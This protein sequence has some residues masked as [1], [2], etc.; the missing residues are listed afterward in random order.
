MVAICLLQLYKFLTQ[1]F[2]SFEW[3]GEAFFKKPP[4]GLP[5]SFAKFASQTLNSL[6]LR[7]CEDD[8]GGGLTKR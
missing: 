1:N 8:K 5:G 7:L 2:L 4:G 3:V 6:P